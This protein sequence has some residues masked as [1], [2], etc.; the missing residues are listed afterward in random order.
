MDSP[1]GHGHSQRRRVFV[2]VDSGAVQ[3]VFASWDAAETFADDKQLSLDR[4]LE[5]E[6]SPDHPDHFH[7]MSAK[8]G[9]VWKFVGEWTRR[10]P[11]WKKPP[12]RIRM[13]HYYMRFNEMVLLRQKEFA[14]EDGL[15]GKINPMAPDAALKQ[16]VK[17]RPPTE[18]PEWKPTIAPLKPLRKEAQ[19]ESS[20][21]PPTPPP[22]AAEKPGPKPEPKH[23]EPEETTEAPEEPLPETPKIKPRLADPANPQEAETKPPPKP[24]EEGGILPLDQKPRISFSKRP[25]LRLKSKKPEPKPIPAFKPASPGGSTSVS[26]PA[27]IFPGGSTSVSTPA[28][29]APDSPE[30]PDSAP[31]KPRRIWPLRLI[32]P[33]AAIVLFWASGLYWALKPP[34]MAAEVVTQVTTLAR[35]RLLLIEPGQVFFQLPV[36]PAHQ[37]RW[38]R[39]LGLDAIPM[40]QTLEIPQYHALDTWEKPDGFIRPP[41]G[42]VEVREWWNLRLRTVNYG[43]YHEWED[44]S[45]IILDL[46]SDMLV[47]WARAD[48]LPELMN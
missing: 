26:T 42:A 38:V 35:A 41:Y 29:A 32:L 20:G 40:G 14:W 27:P 6:T 47:G 39:N 44:G 37:Q 22:E 45:I 8:W 43:F 11:R 13:D 9:N 10:E 5:F 48:R 12:D 7:L 24:E 3:G 21:P 17:S 15:L 25:P 36:D 2:L 16:V 30:P 33:V 34:T 4:L 28:P 1:V 31:A 23:P 46:G 19:A 18:I